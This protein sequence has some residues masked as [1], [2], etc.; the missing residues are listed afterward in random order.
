MTPRLRKFALTVHVA[1]SVGWLGAVIGFL[2]HA[3]AG[4][5]SQDNQTVRAA[6]MMMALTGWFVLVPLSFAS[7][8]T[9]VVQSLGTAWGLFRHYWVIAKLSI[10][11]F[12]AVVLLIYMQTLDKAATA[13]QTTFSVAD[14]NGHHGAVSPLIHGSTAL[15]LLITCVVLSVYKPWG[16]T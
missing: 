4:L 6:Y 5:T 14:L 9:G 2:A 7:L 13:A 3:V 10:T 15:L 12:A 8:L 16:K 11:V 1:A